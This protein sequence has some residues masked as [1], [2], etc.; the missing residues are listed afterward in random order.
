MTADLPRVASE[1]RLD[2]TQQAAFE[3]AMAA[4]RERSAARSAMPPASGGSTLFGGGRRPN[5][6]G[7]ADASSNDGVMRQRIQERLNQQF[8]GF[9]ATLDA[10]R[11]ARWDAEILALVSA[12]RA[13][14]Y[15]LVDGAPEA[16]M[17]RVGAS[18]GS[19]TEVSGALKAGDEVIIG[20]VRAA[21]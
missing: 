3:A 1:L 21:P 17:V 8:S 10:G 5:G 6:N 16:V 12:R 2:D 7:Q 20:T 19:W 13:P 15:K 11:Q 14:L 9:R 4:V 18:D